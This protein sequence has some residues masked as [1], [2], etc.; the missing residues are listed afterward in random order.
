MQPLLTQFVE[1]TDNPSE[2]SNAIRFLD[3]AP[4]M[5]FCC[6]VVV[7]ISPLLRQVNG[8][9]V[10]RRPMV[11]SSVLIQLGLGVWLY[12]SILSDIDEQIGVTLQC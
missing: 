6:W 3:L 12:S 4:A 9:A 10:L 11:D 5:E 7:V 8:P 1:M 2:E